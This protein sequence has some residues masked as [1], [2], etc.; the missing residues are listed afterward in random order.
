MAD[1]GQ[2]LAM[3][4]VLKDLAVPSTGG[5]EQEKTIAASDAGPVTV[6]VTQ[7]ADVG[8]MLALSH[9]LKDLAVPNTIG[10]EQEKNIV[11]PNA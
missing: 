3:S 6:P 8:H 10:V 2:T 11:A 4:H 1:V 7:R 5:V 9:V